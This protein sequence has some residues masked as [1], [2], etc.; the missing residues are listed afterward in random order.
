MTATNYTDFDMISARALREFYFPAIDPGTPYYEWGFL[1]KAGS[2]SLVNATANYDM[3]DDFGGTILDDSVTYD[4]GTN[5][6]AL[7]KVS[8]GQVRMLQSNDSQVEACPTYYSIRNKTHTPATGQRWEMSTYQTPGATTVLGNGLA[9]NFRYVYV[10]DP[11]SN[12]NQYPAGGAQF[13]QV[14]VAAHLAA[15][16]LVLDGDPVGPYQQKFIAM[17]ATAVRNDL[18]QKANQEGGGGV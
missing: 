2:I 14:V 15:A 3:P 18:N 17:L 4:A 9:L 1:R 7:V 10:P 6:P 5:K 8:E 16:E 13:S 11:L 12:T